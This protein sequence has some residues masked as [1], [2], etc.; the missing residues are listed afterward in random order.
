MK[1]VIHCEVTCDR[2]G[3]VVFRQYKNA[4]TISYLK[5]ATKDWEYTNEFGNTCPEC[6]K[7]LRKE[8]ETKYVKN[9]F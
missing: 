3:G 8:R 6:L 4:E 1:A 5:K 2:C 9:S 7:E